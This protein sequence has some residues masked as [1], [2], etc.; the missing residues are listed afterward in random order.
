VCVCPVD[1][2]CNKVLLFLIQK[3]F[4]S[5][6]YSRKK[7][8]RESR[9]C[10][11]EDGARHGEERKDRQARMHWRMCARHAACIRQL[12][13]EQA[14]DQVTGAHGMQRASRSGA[15]CC[16]SVS[17]RAPPSFGS[18]TRG[19]V[20]QRTAATSWPLRASVPQPP[21][22][23][24]DPARGWRSRGGEE[25]DGRRCRQSHQRTNLQTSGRRT[26]TMCA[27]QSAALVGRQCLLREA[28]LEL[29][30]PGARTAF[31]FAVECR[32]FRLEPGIS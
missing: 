31:G 22:D 28:S 17:V 30:G 8:R 5:P 9:A 4:S 13:I 24:G 25:E 29:G 19:L 21:G 16:V 23:R 6:A 1:P 10:T 12:A 20:A 14:V 18:Y 2:R 3:I 11:N 7:R 27:L 15:D 32:P 26:T